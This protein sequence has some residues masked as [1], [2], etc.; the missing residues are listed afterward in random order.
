MSKRKDKGLK[1]LAEGRVFQLREGEFIV[2]SERGDGE[3]RVTWSRDRW[4]CSC[5]DF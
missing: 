4:V 3:Y 5:P 1:L 2:K